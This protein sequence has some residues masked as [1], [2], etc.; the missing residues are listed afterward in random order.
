MNRVVIKVWRGLLSEVYATDKDTEIIV[1][2][3]DDPDDCPEVQ[4]PE[5]QVY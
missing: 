3:E 5:H 1:L 4:I 2:D